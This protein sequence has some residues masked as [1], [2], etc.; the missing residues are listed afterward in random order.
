MAPSKYIF[1]SCRLS[2]NAV[3]ARYHCHSRQ[4]FQ[5]PH[6]PILFAFRP[7]A[8]PDPSIQAVNDAMANWAFAQA[9]A[10]FAP[11]ISHL[12]VANLQQQQQQQQ[13]QIYQAKSK[14][15]A[16]ANALQL[17]ESYEAIAVANLQQQ[18]YQVQS[19]D[20][21]KAV[22]NLQQQQQ[23]MYQAKSHD[24]AKSNALQLKE[25]YEAVAAAKLQQQKQQI[26][27]AKS[28]DEAKSNALQLKE[29]Y[30]AKAN[31]LKSQ[32]EAKAKALQL[33]ENYEAK[34]NA[35]KLKENYERYLKTQAIEMDRRMAKNVAT[36]EPVAHEEPRVAPTTKDA[37]V[38]QPAAESQKRSSTARPGAA[39]KPRTEEDNAAGTILLGFLSS[40]RQS[41]EDALVGKQKLS[42]INGPIMT[43]R[44]SVETSSSSADSIGSGGCDGPADFF[45]QKRHAVPVTDA[46]S[47]TS[48]QVESSVDDSDWNSDKKTDP[49][50][51]EDS[52]KEVN[53]HYSKGPPRKRM[54]T[55]KLADERR[56]S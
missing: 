12:A 7:T 47:G 26:Y 27:Q 8:P 35:L 49:S 16:S 44:K 17:K 6:S 56:A 53:R 36:R 55:K 3:S 13:Q 15:E 21:A 32:D 45:K 50:S 18:M 9:A 52:D 5:S 42:N 28:Q 34:A 30:E 41:Y 1:S 43:S 48:Q 37:K 54:K 23:Q 20:E 14:D 31:A 33:K 22:V 39:K 29:S 46:S 51:S 40:L 38:E 10:S 19:Q 2:R 25:S 11:A 24:E 4:E